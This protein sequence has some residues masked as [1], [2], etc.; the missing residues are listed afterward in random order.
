[1]ATGPVEYLL[2]GFPG[3]NFTGEIA[4]EL[5]KLISSGTIR[6]LDLV[7]LSKDSDGEVTMLEVDE[8]EALASFTALDGDVGGLIGS[9]DVQHAAQA[10]APDSSAGL[11]IWEDVWAAPFAN[12]LRNANGVLLE[13]G[14]IP[15]QL[16]APA[17]AAL[18]DPV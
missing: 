16:I 8:L 4:S 17:L 14:R 10:L 11:L 9:E 6:V 7:F 13:G 15:Y 12:A 3:N 1:M 2:V 5:E 18:P